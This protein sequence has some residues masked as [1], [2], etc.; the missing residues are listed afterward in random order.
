MSY[1]FF[2]YGHPNVRCTHKNTFEFTKDKEVSLDGDCIIGVNSDFDVNEIKKIIKNK[3]KK[4]EQVKINII[5]DDLVEEVNC[6]V[7]LAFSDDHEIVVRRSNFKSER[8]LGLYS[9]KACIDFSEDF[10]RKLK[11]KDQKIKVVIE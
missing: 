10:R 2:S 4:E 7:N 11:N 8:T 6:L 9:D 5:V 1:S 3:Q